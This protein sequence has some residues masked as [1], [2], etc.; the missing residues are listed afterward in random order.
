MAAI[1]L[2][3]A[4]TKPDFDA[5]TTL[6]PTPA[7]EFVTLREK[8]MARGG[9]RGGRSNQHQTVGMKATRWREPRDVAS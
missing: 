1:A 4:P 2:K 8:W 3:P 9:S 6:H 5:T 7:K